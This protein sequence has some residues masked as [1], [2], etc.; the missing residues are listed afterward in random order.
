M[1]RRLYI[2]GRV[3]EGIREHLA[4]ATRDALESFASA[5]EDEDTMTGHLGAKLEARHRTVLVTQDEL[6]GEWKW[7]LTYYKFRGRGPRPTEFYVGADG[8]FELK[9][10]I[11]ARTETKS[12][13]F[14]AKMDGQ[15]GVNLL[16]QCVKLSTWREAAFVANY[17]ER[18]YS[19]V[20]LD[21]VIAHRGAGVSFTNAKPLHEYLGHD[22]LDCLVGDDELRYEPGSHRLIW[23][24]ENGEIVAT[25]FNVKHRFRLQIQAPRDDGAIAGVDKDISAAELSKYRMAATAEE[26]LGL[27]ASP[28]A[29][30]LRDARRRLAVAFH[31][32][33]FLNLDQ[34]LQ[35]LMT[36]RM[37]EV[38]A[39]YDALRKRK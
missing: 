30:S 39:A 27:T 9:L 35:G 4:S 22:F 21:D 1:R 36:R 3:K 8:L 5:A 17:S 31:P 12:V 13:L 20:S 26:I 29:S 19:A 28:T 15:G 32:D 38:N 34:L 25:R 24:A 11:G 14:Q 18:G 2:P 33:Q 7:S 6:A 16:E 37:Q 23:R 10:S